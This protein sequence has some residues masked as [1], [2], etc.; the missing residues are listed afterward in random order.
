MKIRGDSNIY[1]ISLL[2]DKI[3]SHHRVG[4]HVKMRDHRCGVGP[5]DTTT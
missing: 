1:T 3:V 5:F 4:T 2:Q